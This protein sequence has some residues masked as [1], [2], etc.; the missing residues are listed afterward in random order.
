MIDQDDRDE[1]PDSILAAECGCIL[2]FN[3]NALTLYGC[4]QQ[5][6]VYDAVICWQVFGEEDLN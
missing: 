2:G 1:V 4:G 3:G 6:A 5:C